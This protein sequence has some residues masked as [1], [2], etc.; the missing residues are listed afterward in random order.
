VRHQDI[1]EQRVDSVGDWLLEAKEFRGWYNGSENGGSNH[2][3]LFC[4]EE[5]G[6]GK[7]Y[8]WY[9]TSSARNEDMI[10]DRSR[11]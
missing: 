8:I 6:A 10:A 3:A 7:S 5:P 4:Y 1:C 2:V 9:E 11:W